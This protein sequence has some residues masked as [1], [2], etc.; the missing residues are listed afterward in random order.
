MFYPD[1]TYYPLFHDMLCCLCS[2]DKLCAKCELIDG[3]LCGEYAQ[4]G[5]RN[6]KSL[7]KCYLYY[8]YIGII[9]TFICNYFKF[10]NIFKL[11]LE[12]FPVLQ[13]NQKI[14]KVLFT[15]IILIFILFEK[16]ISMNLVT[17]L[18]HKKGKEK[19]RT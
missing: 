1:K 14:H 15:M 3:D 4:H 12:S 6:C 18:P 5:K 2:F 8:L 19:E 9:V 17:D 11:L 10:L 16:Q 13:S 7:L